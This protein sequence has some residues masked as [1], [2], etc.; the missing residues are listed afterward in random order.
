MLNIVLY[1][2]TL[3]NTIFQQSP[4]GKGTTEITMDYTTQRT[5]EITTESTTDYL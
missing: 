2:F 5:T 1:E 4:L 3:T